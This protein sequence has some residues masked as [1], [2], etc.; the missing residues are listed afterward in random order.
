MPKKSASSA[1]GVRG[2]KKGPR[3]RRS[4]DYSDIPPLSDPQLRSMRRVGRPLLGEGARQLIAI[5]V[6]PQVLDELR[7]EAERQSV[8]YQTLV[9]RVLA[10]YVR[11]C[12]S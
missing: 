12:A 3:T 2:R 4:I 1:Q 10:D 8:G 9:N 6:D 5:R 11:K 7:R